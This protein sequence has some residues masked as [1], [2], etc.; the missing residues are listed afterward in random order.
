IIVF[1]TSIGA[2]FFMLK[3]VVPMFSDVFLN[4]GGEL[5]WIT[6]FIVKVSDI[7]DQTFGGA[8]L[9]LLVVLFT[10]YLNRRKEWFRKAISSIVLRIPFVGDIVRKTQLSQFANTMRLLISTNVPLLQSI[11]LVRQMS[12]FFPIEESLKAT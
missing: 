2:V 10:M 6:A 1:C 12:N 4:F 3:F 7:I 11:Q 9:I 5:P 8:V